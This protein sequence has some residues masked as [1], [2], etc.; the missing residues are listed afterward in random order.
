MK[1][2][3]IAVFSASLLLAGCGNSIPDPAPMPLDPLTQQ[4]VGKTL[5][6]ESTKVQLQEFNKLSGRTGPNSDIVI[7]GAWQVRRGQFCRTITA[8][9]QIAGTECQDVV[10]DG[11]TATF[12]TSRG[13]QTFIISDS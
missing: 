7:D 11:Q 1:S 10:I 2:F 5:T 13:D 6:N 9:E 12:K 8:P 4:L 3:G